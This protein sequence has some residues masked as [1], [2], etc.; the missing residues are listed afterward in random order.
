MNM[1]Y[2]YFICDVF[3][4]SQFGGNQLA[5]FPAAEGLTEGQMQQIARE[6]NFAETTFVL[7]AESGHSFRVRIF[8]PAREV[9]FAGHPNLG[10][11]FVLVSQN[12]L[13]NTFGRNVKSA[14]L[15]FE[16][17]AGIVRV[18]VQEQKN[19]LLLCELTAPQK[20]ELGLQVPASDVAMALSLHENQIVTSRHLPQLASVGLPFLMVEL[21]DREALQQAR[22][23]GAGFD[24]LAT[25]G[26]MPDLHMYVRSNDDFDLRARMFAPHDGVPEDAATGSANCALA[27]MLAMMDSHDD[28]SLS[29]RIAQGVEMG[30]PSVL[31]ASAEKKAGQVTAVRIAGHCALF[32]S[33]KVVLAL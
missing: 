25:M 12:L 3:T 28:A 8:T 13:G 30:R 11:A 5:V 32:A 19:G 27:G 26:F 24:K 23:N 1:N 18:S 31:L 7:P 20:I 16:E 2:P 33:G 21:R 10:T 9:P 4:K 15:E 6:F 29:W 17:A 22:I 14:V